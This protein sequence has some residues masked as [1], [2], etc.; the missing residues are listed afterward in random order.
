MR[1]AR[2]VRKRCAIRAQKARAA[3]QAQLGHKKPNLCV[4]EV[5]SRARGSNGNHERS[6]ARVLRKFCGVM[7]DDGGRYCEAEMPRFGRENT[8]RL[9]LKPMTGQAQRVHFQLD[10]SLAASTEGCKKQRCT[11]RRYKTPH[12]QGCVIRR[13]QSLTASTAVRDPAR[14]SEI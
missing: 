10:H 13:G 14:P 4:I 12:Q 2:I 7:D 6:A 9:V 3:T 5:L 11:I 8:Q 1:N